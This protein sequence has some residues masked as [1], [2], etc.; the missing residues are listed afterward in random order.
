MPEAPPKFASFR[1]K[2]AVP[3]AAPSRT[4]SPDRRK[5]V[6]E[7]QPLRKSTSHRHHHSRRRRDGERSTDELERKEQHLNQKDDVPPILPQESYEAASELFIVDR[8]GDLGNVKYGYNERY[9]V[10]D[11]KE[12]PLRKLLGD[13]GR[14]REARGHRGSPLVLLSRE[15]RRKLREDE[16][17]YVTTDNSQQWAQTDLDFIVLLSLIHI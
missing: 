4:T 1:A 11:Y 16:T 5:S 9:K 10:P 8:R 17:V 14:L 13:D 15:D 3:P 12:P 7:D 2:P 6:K